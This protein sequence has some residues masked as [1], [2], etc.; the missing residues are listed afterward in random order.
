[1]N[2]L[3]ISD[4]SEKDLRKIISKQVKPIDK[5]KKYWFNF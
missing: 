5:K 1:M 4:L 2:F 3:N